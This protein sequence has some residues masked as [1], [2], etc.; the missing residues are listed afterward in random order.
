MDLPAPITSNPLIS[1]HP[2]MGAIPYPGGTAFRVWAKFATQ[3]Y[4]VGD[5]NQWDE[6]ANSLAPEGNGYWS[7]DVFAA[8]EG[9]LY[10]YVIHSPFLAK[11]QYRT[12][13]YA[14]RVDKIRVM[15]TLLLL[16]L[17]GVKT[18][19]RCHRGMNW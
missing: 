13:P 14:K 12:D 5:F 4:V 9:D 17:I 3:V 1:H 15:A 18:T 16:N 7:V 6:S 8:K 10:R 11:P 19:L 2:G